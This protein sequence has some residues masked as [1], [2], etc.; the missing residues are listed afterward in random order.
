[1]AGGAGQGEGQVGEGEVD[2]HLGW[3]F[4]GL[5]FF[6]VGL[7]VYRHIRSLGDLSYYFPLHKNTKQ[8]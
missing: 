5:N 4:L 8:I 2:G 7:Y 1:V 6:I 3:D